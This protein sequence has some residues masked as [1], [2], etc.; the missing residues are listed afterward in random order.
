MNKNLSILLAALCI[1]F[2][3]STLGSV[4]YYTS[5]IDD[6]NSQ[7]ANKPKLVVDGL[8]VE[9]NRGSMG[10]T[11]RI[12]GRINNTGEGT[13]Y[14]ALL[15]VIAFNAEGL[16]IDEYYN[17]VGITGGMSLGVDFGL[18][19]TGSPI[20]SYAI[21]PTYTDVLPTPVNGTLPSGG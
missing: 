20:E 3:I 1:I 15:H 18:N 5:V 2:L 16:A 21:S 9:D 14:N 11:L 7:I 4:V 8:N 19:Y 17:F 12:Y 10:N 6:L 13:A